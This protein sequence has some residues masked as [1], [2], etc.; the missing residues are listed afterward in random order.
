MQWCLYAVAELLKASMHSQVDTIYVEGPFSRPR[1]MVPLVQEWKEFKAPIFRA[2]L[3]SVASFAYHF[4]LE[5]LSW[6]YLVSIS[7][8]L[9]SKGERN[10]MTWKNKS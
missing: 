6:D 3:P 2:P 5:S 7:Y 8:L 10:T 9:F 4:Q 1:K